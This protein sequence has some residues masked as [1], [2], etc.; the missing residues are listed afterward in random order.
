MVRA[1]I[2]R[3]RDECFSQ[4][5]GMDL[6]VWEFAVIPIDQDQS[7][8]RFRVLSEGGKVGVRV[9]NTAYTH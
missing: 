5:P 2:D 7:A 1:I 9:D 3:G 8:L 6:R 4:L